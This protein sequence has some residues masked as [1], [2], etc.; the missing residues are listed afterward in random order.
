M[1]QDSTKKILI[2]DDEQSNRRLME[3]F[4]TA[5]GYE[6]VTAS[7][8][9]EA[10]SV[11]LAQLPAIVVLD[12]IMPGMDGFQVVQKLKENPLTAHIPII[13]VSAVSDKAAQLRVI[14]SGVDDVIGK[15]VN[16]WE[17]SL[18]LRRLLHIA[19]VSQAIPGVAVEPKGASEEDVK[20]R[21]HWR[22]LNRLL[23]MLNQVNR[24][25][26][27]VETP[28]SL[29]AQVCQLVVES[30]I[31]DL[32][33]IGLF[34]PKRCRLRPMAR[35]GKSSKLIDGLYREGA[36]FD[37]SS[38]LAGERRV[39]N[40]LSLAEESWWCKDEALSC[41]FHSAACLPISEFGKVIGLV[42]IYSTQV[43][44]FDVEVA[45]L[46]EELTEDLSFAQEYFLQ[47]QR[48]IVA[49]TRAHYLAHYEQQTGLP[50]RASLEKHLTEMTAKGQDVA[51][52]IIKL[53]RLEPIVRAF[54]KAVL[55]AM[56]RT[57]AQRLESCKGRYGMAAQLAPDEFAIATPET[58]DLSQVDRL[59]SEVQSILTQALSTGSSEAYVRVG[60]GIAVSTP[61]DGSPWLSLQRAQAAAASVIDN[62]GICYYR[63]EMDADTASRIALESEL[64]RAVEKGEFELHYQPQ[65]NLKTGVIVG[66]EAL[67][68]WRHA[69]KGLISPG[70]FIPLLEDSGLMTQMGEWVLRTA[71]RQH[72][73]W[74][75]AGLPPL[76]MAVNLSAQQFQRSELV[77]VV[78][79]VLNETGMDAT[80][81]EL[82]L[83]E[84][85]ILEDAEHTIHM[86]H[87]LKALNVTLSLDDFGTGYSSLSYLRRFPVDRIK[88]D[89][90]FV[91][92]VA[93][94][95]S[96]ASL[97]R[98]ILA[99]AHNL[100]LATLAEG[101]ETESQLG[102][103]RRHGCQ[104]MQ[105]F[106]FSAALPPA[107]LARLV[108]EGMS[109]PAEKEGGE[110]NA[111]VVIV[112]DEA[113]VLSALKRLLRQDGVTV[114]TAE[115][116]EKAFELLAT[117]EVGVVIS[118]QRMRKTTGI[119][120]L[121]Q[122]KGLYPESLRILLT[123]Y[124]E[125]NAVIDAVN[126]G[127]VFKVLTK[128]WNDNQMRETVREALKNYN[129]LRENRLMMQRLDAC[130][131]QNPA[132]SVSA[133]QS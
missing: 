1:V 49:E 87:E 119:E 130:R 66:V 6:A 29:Y 105:G 116:D 120:F 125:L 8:G 57:L 124:A 118:D 58:A 69:G 132:D 36:T 126:R 80:W 18:R 23:R 123:G 24:S 15:P 27:R 84:S 40:D 111:T 82:E 108:R 68:R 37:W 117:T 63:P 33:W 113:N 72:Q 46:L 129:A 35:F 94:Q 26:V 71:C 4:V 73:S 60:I 5:E 21:A 102:Y 20:E 28:D 86:M 110:V 45:G 3:V 56:M 81:L 122:V 92:D 97:V 64:H 50:N 14:A 22:R 31:F 83:T 48:L 115:N 79:N 19:A 75:E 32:A 70:L 2:V 30:G 59:A 41:G 114:L 17:L 53:R 7:S 9:E 55:D 13:I 100:G 77:Q 107:D 131:T 109:L 121:D 98:T 103:L 91:C 25:V 44:Q 43:R 89:R 39:C 93:T 128:P 101:V 12:L 127:A 104:E 99:M 78:Q 47:Q 67:L 42:E 76:R 95:S 54:G 16:R 106:L 11:A 62:S 34:E 65:L 133:G 112:D 90:S 51:V 74:L 10:L 38:V 85:L 52:L 96:S 61:G 88:V